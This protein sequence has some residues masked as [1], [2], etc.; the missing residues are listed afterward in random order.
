MLS[1]ARFEESDE[2]HIRIE[3]QKVFSKF[4]LQ[5]NF[6]FFV[7]ESP[8]FWLDLIICCSIRSSN[9]KE[10]YFFDCFDDIQTLFGQSISEWTKLQSLKTLK[11]HSLDDMKFKISLQKQFSSFCAPVSQ[12]IDLHHYS[13]VADL[14]QKTFLQHLKEKA[15]I[16][17][18]TGAKTKVGGM[19]MIAVNP[20]PAGYY[21]E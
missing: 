20:I 4:K 5:T 15:K 10:I 19:G 1:I 17:N 12:N 7:T 21:H 8:V 16:N 2:E 6:L 18:V 14:N 11:Q 13:D 9:E 3:K